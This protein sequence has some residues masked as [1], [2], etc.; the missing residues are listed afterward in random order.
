MWGSKNKTIGEVK[1]KPQGVNYKQNV[2]GKVQTKPQ[3]VNYKQNVKGG[4]K[5]LIENTQMHN[6]NK[7]I[8]NV[9][10]KFKGIT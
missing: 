3:G 5:I 4:G 7:K 9:R 10:I 2:K 6:M 1:T 8:L